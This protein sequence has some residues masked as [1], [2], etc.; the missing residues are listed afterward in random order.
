MV[1]KTIED[2]REYRGNN[3]LEVV[4]MEFYEATGCD[5]YVVA[6]MDTTAVV[7]PEH[8]RPLVRLWL[9]TTA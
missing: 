2:P 4:R 5:L 6:W 3:F 1:W 8:A 7:R 9:Q